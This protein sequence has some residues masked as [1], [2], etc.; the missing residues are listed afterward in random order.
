M[1]E[2]PSLLMKSIIYLLDS[3]NIPIATGFVMRYIDNL[4]DDYS[5]YAVTCQH[6]IQHTAVLRFFDGTT[7]S[8]T[9]SNWSIP[10]NGNDIGIMDVTS[11][12]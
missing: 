6:C 12:I 7:V 4:G 2:I 5:C 9:P 3:Q 1:P 8:V 10:S 11:E